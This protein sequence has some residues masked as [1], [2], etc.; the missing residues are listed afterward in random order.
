MPRYIAAQDIYD[1]EIYGLTSTLLNT[2]TVELFIDDAEYL[3]DGKAAKLY[4]VPFT[5]T[6][7]PW[8]VKKLARDMA[9]YYCLDYLYSQQQVNKNDWV[10]G[11]YEEAMELLDQIANDDLRLVY[12]LSAGSVGVLTP[13]RARN[14][15]GTYTD[16]PSVI[17]MDSQWSWDV[18]GTLLDD[19]DARRDAAE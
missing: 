18:P 14:L 11:K 9:G 4:T 16:I 6:G 2:A 19:I 7:I 1:Y 5:S 13:N 17:N 15:V 12:S 3:I 8:M 10:E